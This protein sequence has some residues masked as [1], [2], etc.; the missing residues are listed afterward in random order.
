MVA[1]T[2]LLFAAS[3]ILSLAF[4]A[5]IRRAPR[6]LV[7]R[8]AYHVYGG[9][10]STGEGWPA[11]S[12]WL[13]FEDLWT[14]NKP[15]IQV[16]CSQ[17]STANPTDDEVQSI[18]DALVSVSSS[19]G[20][21]SAFLLAIMMQESKGCP[22]VPT[23]TYSN[24][25][26]GLFQSFNGKGSCNTGGTITNPCP[27][28]MITTMVSEGA[29]LG[30]AFGLTQAITQSNVNDVS[31]YYKGARIYNSGSI[32]PGGNL[33]SGVAT[34]CYATDIA[35]RLTGWASGSSS[36]QETTI[37]SVGG[38]STTT[39]D[40]SNSST[41]NSQTNNNTNTNTNTT[42]ATNSPTAPKAAGASGSCKSW[43]TVK[44]G[45]TCEST[46]VSLSKLI[47]LNTSLD[48]NCSNLW[49]GSAYCTAA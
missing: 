8:N 44:A 1:T 47:E 5:P 48:A 21:P 37:A 39:T 33:G 20:I 10:G 42:P 26:P 12:S 35:N 40:N 3:S 46:G 41:D 4:A 43:Y 7:E 36:C 11:Q 38:S 9:D 15:I 25:N 2:S 18:H 49:A 14:A 6:S 31:K 17:F 27:P 34:H 29:G 28:A 24:T 16:S 19:A 32:G 13:S 30:L 23:T 22:R 45:D